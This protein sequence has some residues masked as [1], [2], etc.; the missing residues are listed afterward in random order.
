MDALRLLES[1]EQNAALKSS[2][3][4]LLANLADYR[5]TASI[6]IQPNLLDRISILLDAE[7]NLIS[8]AALRAVRLLSKHRYYS[9]AS[10]FS[11]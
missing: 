7:N 9:R 2:I 6:V 8:E 1:G 5:E 11:L 10:V 3:L 4:R